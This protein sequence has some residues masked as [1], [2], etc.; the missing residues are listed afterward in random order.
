MTVSG[1]VVRSVGG[2]VGLGVGAGA[3]S[4]VTTVVGGR[5]V[6]V[7]GVWVTGVNDV[8]V[9]VDM[10]RGVVIGSVGT[11]DGVGVAIGSVGGRVGSTDGVGVGISVGRAVSMPSSVGSTPHPLQV[12]LH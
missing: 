4:E 5:D 6:V 9:M 11:I 10:V 1:T 3:G 12:K 7:G 8:G 2:R